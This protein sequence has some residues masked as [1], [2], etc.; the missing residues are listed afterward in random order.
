M[1]F[2]A[3]AR[4]LRPTVFGSYKRYSTRKAFARNLR[5]RHAREVERKKGDS[6]D[7]GKA[8]RELNKLYEKWE[9]S[10]FVFLHTF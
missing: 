1:R 5:E 10:L 6:Y 8:G 7:N 4:N 3:N 9:E 2:L